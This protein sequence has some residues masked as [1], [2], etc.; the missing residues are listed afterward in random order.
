[1]KNKPDDVIKGFSRVHNDKK[2]LKTSVLLEKKFVFR[3]S[4]LTNEFYRLLKDYGNFVFRFKDLYRSP[5][6]FW[7]LMNREIR[8][9]NVKGKLLYEVSTASKT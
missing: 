5:V 1:M 4:L 7:S 3:N 9:E 8:V 2:R 6:R